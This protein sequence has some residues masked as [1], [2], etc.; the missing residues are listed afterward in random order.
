MNNTFETH[1][2]VSLQPRARARIVP[3]AGT[4]THAGQVIHA[5]FGRAARRVASA[6]S[7]TASG[8]SLGPAVRALHVPR[9]LIVDADEARCTELAELFE[10]IGY[11]TFE[12]LD[13][14]QAS[15]WQ[16]HLKHVDVVLLNLNLEDG[17]AF[18]FLASAQVGLVDGHRPAVVVLARADQRLEAIRA[19]HEGAFDWQVS[20]IDIALLTHSIARATEQ[21]RLRRVDRLFQHLMLSTP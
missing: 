13:I 14:A 15:A 16:Q 4:E 20:P 18:D 10:D 11:E 8:E 19:L 6:R 2:V 12:A 21:V 1:R 5:Q 17:E 3:P 7:D 9:L